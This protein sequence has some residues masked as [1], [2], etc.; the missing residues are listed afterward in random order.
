MLGARARAAE[1]NAAKA[2]TARQQASKESDEL[3]LPLKPA[4][5]SLSAFTRNVSHSR[6]RGTKTFIPLILSEE[7]EMNN[8]NNNNNTDPTGKVDQTTSTHSDPVTR[9]ASLPPLQTFVANRPEMGPNVQTPLRYKSPRLQSQIHPHSARSVHLDD[10]YGLPVTGIGFHPP[11]F[12]PFQHA[13]P[14]LS[15]PTLIHTPYAGW[16][17]SPEYLGS[18][19]PFFDAETPS[20]I[21]SDELLPR[22]YHRESSQE[23]LVANNLAKRSSPEPVPDRVH[24]TIPPTKFGGPTLYIYGPDD[25]SPTKI[26]IKQRAR[27]EYFAKHPPSASTQAANAIADRIDAPQ[28]SQAECADRM[29]RPVHIR[30]DNFIKKT[31]RRPSSIQDLLIDHDNVAPVRPRGTAIGASQFLQFE[32]PKESCSPNRRAEPPATYQPSCHLQYT[33]QAH[34]SPMRH[35]ENVRAKIL[36]R[37]VDRTML[38]TIKSTKQVEDVRRIRRNPTSESDENQAKE[39]ADELERQRL[40]QVTDIKF[41][42]HDITDPDW[43]EF[44]DLTQEDRQWIRLVRKAIASSSISIKNDPDCIKIKHKDLRGQCHR[45]MGEY[46]RRSRHVQALADEMQ[47]KWEH[48]GQFR[49]PIMTKQEAESQA[50]KIKEI[51]RIMIMLSMQP[52]DTDGLNYLGSRPYVEPPEYAIERSV[53]TEKERAASLFEEDGEI[54]LA[55]PPRL[56]RDPRFR[57]QLNE[58][59]KIRGDEERIPRMFVARA[60]LQN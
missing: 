59:M 13:Q 31:Q 24:P 56:A 60:R 23:P 16:Y 54:G 47:H 3:Q 8:N 46:E 12:A 33:G 18:H 41:P 11:Q 51:G 30:R 37:D 4:P 48:G 15:H 28:L 21:P 7:E 36:E 44:R 50:G 52:D 39:I 1:Y 19:H 20:I 43:C 6:N 58:G 2:A 14:M 10:G 49:G 32:S 35:M 34:Q 55:A 29:A 5:V 26:E 17:P 38:D 9:A 22:R 42:L 27:E 40:E 53:G 57:A 25:L 45:D